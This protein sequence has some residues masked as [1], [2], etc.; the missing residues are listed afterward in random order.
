[1]PFIVGRP[2]RVA[3]Q[4]GRGQ[5]HR[6]YALHRRVDVVRV[7]EEELRVALI[8]KGLSDAQ[9]V[10]DPGIRPAFDGR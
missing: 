5:Q 4:S 6:D 10:F 3:G 1:M 7:G 2:R 8:V 9:E